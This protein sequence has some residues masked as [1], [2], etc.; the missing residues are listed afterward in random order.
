MVDGLLRLSFVIAIDISNANLLVALE[1]SLKV[2]YHDGCY[3][4]FPSAGNVG[5]EKR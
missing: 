3:H 4:R 2:V 5:T 1:T